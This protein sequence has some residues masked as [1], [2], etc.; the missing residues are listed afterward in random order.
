MTSAL[1]PLAEGVEEMEA[2]IAIDVLRRAQWR[3]ITVG[4]QAGFLTASRGV[5]LQPD[6]TWGAVD[7]AAWDA[8]VIP[9]G[10]GGVRSLVRD[11]RV[12]AAVRGFHVQR[13]WV[14]AICAAP[15]VLQAAGI[16]TAT[17]RVTCHPGAAAELTVTKRLD[18]TTVVDGRLVTSQGPGT[19]FE[20]ALTLV[21]LIDG[22]AAA[23]SLAA[24]MVLSASPG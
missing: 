18:E 16:L 20:F 1:I 14:A 4:L 23:R 24:S 15:L 13:K 3:V 7:P 11:E 10:A 5:R 22:A 2:V 19:A 17:S 21:R 8:L 12:L 9:G 6:E